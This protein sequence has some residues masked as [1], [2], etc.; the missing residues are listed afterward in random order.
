MN[1]PDDAGVV[2]RLFRVRP[3]EGARVLWMLV[4]SLAA[5]GGVVITGQLVGRTLFLSGLPADA[6]PYRFI[7]SPLALVAVVAA[8]THLAARV[9]HVRLIAISLGVMLAGTLALR[10][11]LETDLSGS[12]AF[13]LGQIVWFDVIG[14]V[15]M[16]LFW[17]VAGDVFDAREARRLFGLVAGGSAISNVV[18]GAVLLR[19][20]ARVEPEGLLLLTV[21]SLAVCLGVVGV[22]RR[23]IHHERADARGPADVPVGLAAAL[24]AGLSEL[25]RPPLMRT[26]VLIVIVI[27]LV[28]NIADF[29]LDLALKRSFGD[30]AGGM[31]RFLAWFRLCAGVASVVVQFLLVGRLMER[32]GVL[33]ALLV[34]PIAVAGG[35]SFIL[36]TGGMLWAV[37]IPRASDVVL[38]YTLNDAALNLLYLPLAPH[39]RARA[40]AVVDGALKPVILAVLGFVFLAASRMEAV[41][42]VQW[43]VPLIGLAVLWIVLLHRAARQYVAALAESISL[44][45]LDL[46]RERVDLSD[47]TSVR[48]IEQALCAPE[49][50]RVLHTLSLLD[51]ASEGDWSERVVPLLEHAAPEVRTAALRYLAE[52]GSEQYGEA[53]HACLQDPDEH[54][55]VE[56]LSAHARLGGAGAVS[57]LVPFLDDPRPRV[58][59]GAI[60]ALIRHGGLA[61]LLHAGRPLHG[62]L[63]S[64]SPEERAVGA[65]LLGVLGVRNFYGPLLD[66][67]GD[68]EAAVRLAAVRAA[69]EVAAPEL[70]PRLTQALHEPRLR[71]HALRAIERCT[72]DD[73]ETLRALA[74]DVELPRAVRRRIPDLLA[75]R[76]GRAAD[77]LAALVDDLDG[78]VRSAAWAALAGLRAEG[79]AIPLDQRAVLRCLEEEVG[80]VHEHLTRTGPLLEARSAP[81]L[82]EEALA[83]ER[84]ADRERLLMVMTMA[85]PALDRASLREALASTDRRLRA[86]AIELI[87]NVVA[88]DRDR[89]IA[90]LTSEPAPEAAQ[91]AITRIEGESLQ[92]VE[93]LLQ[94]PEPWLRACALHALLSTGS[95]AT[96]VLLFEMLD[97]ADA[98][99]R[100]TAAIEL[101]RRM[102]AAT[103]RVRLVSAEVPSAARAVVE[104]TLARMPDPKEDRPMP[105]AT[106]EKVLFLKDIPLFKELPAEEI[107]PL[108][109]I[110]REVG[111]PAGTDFIRQGDEGD[112]LFVLV[113]GSVQVAI[114]GKPIDHTLGP[115]EVIGELAILSGDK[116]AA[117]CTAQEDVVALEIQR[118]DFWELLREHPEV[119]LGVIKI[120]LGYIRR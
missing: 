110:A 16:I 59:G 68:D 71:P 19:A 52:R 21:A 90:C 93:S 91:H 45:R 118:D 75:R 120:L 15:T 95:S 2:S 94:G 34:L 12:F 14:G 11:L 82:L 53:V 42:L 44:R 26:L 84:H 58:R 35:A 48:V 37:A 49:A 17:T 96:L 104:D 64:A 39:L 6:I 113:E 23:H 92:A 116:R 70:V 109:P 47:E 100:E 13:L 80:R 63:E 1:A 67:L 77:D 111:F 73:L 9:R 27:A 65:R 41:S 79:N 22:L 105:M 72:Q 5:V 62:L 87:D 74:R 107:A 56:A 98:L 55:V 31:V 101:C 43:S 50:A 25:L 78:R 8:T 119:A 88:S 66:L 89:L 108:A 86:N 85:W 51:A 76:G 117:T 114:D 32:F 99:V 69:G 60:V 20:S 106:L 28:G 4:F 33:T 3:G 18:F 7:L 115:G 30:D 112:R 36:L 54:V 102:D 61:G 29:Q 103:L 97:D 10:A 40:K 83:I 81:P 46:P 24:R 38:K 57:E